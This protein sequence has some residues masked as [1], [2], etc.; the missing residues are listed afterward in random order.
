MCS[1]AKQILNCLAQGRSK[2][3]REKLGSKRLISTSIF[4]L[5]RLIWN[6]LIPLKDSNHKAFSPFQQKILL[7]TPPESTLPLNPGPPTW[8]TLPESV[9]CSMSQPSAPSLSHPSTLRGYHKGSTHITRVSSNPIHCPHCCQTG[10]FKSKFHQAHSF[11]FFTDSAEPPGLCSVASVGLQDMVWANL[12][13]SLLS[14][15]LL[16]CSHQPH[17]PACPSSGTQTGFT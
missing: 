11:K 14:T 1:V 7:L 2:Q 12:P 5:P 15:C 4:N 16:S 3:P 10:V 9:H 8:K 17:Q 6:V 13:A